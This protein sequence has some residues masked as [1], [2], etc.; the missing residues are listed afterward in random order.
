MTT[1]RK[2]TPAEKRRR[3]GDRSHRPPVQPRIVGGRVDEAEKLTPPAQVKSSSYALR[4]WRVIVDDLRAGGL[5]D[6]ADLSMVALAAL[7]GGRVD[8]IAAYLKSL[9]TK[10]EPFGHLMAPAKEGTRA[11]PLLAHQRGYI[12]EAR[13]LLGELGI[14]P[15]ARTRLGMDAKG[16]IKPKGMGEELDRKLGP[17]PRLQAIEGGRQ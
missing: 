3:E 10:D 11:H 15:V 9:Q 1:G 8:E 17:N 14:G 7:A 4:W 12:T 5:L 13:Q 16:S 2:P 6:R